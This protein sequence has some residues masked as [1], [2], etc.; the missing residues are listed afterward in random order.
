MPA[1]VRQL[2]AVPE[3][4]AHWGAQV[5]QVALAPSSYFP[6][7]QVQEGAFCLFCGQVRHLVACVSQ[8]AHM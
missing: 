2:S 3:Q 8:V 7:T 4:V 1:Q 6:F 5:A